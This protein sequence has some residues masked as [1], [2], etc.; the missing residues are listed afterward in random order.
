MRRNVWE[1]FEELL[2]DLMEEL[3][4][5]FPE[6]PGRSLGINVTAIATRII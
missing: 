2:G 3:L 5:V 4:Q 1:T 6:D